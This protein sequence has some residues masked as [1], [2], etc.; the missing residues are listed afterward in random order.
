MVTFLSILMA[1]TRAVVYL[2]TPGFYIATARYFYPVVIPLMLLFSAGWMEISFWLS[3]L[4][5]RFR[6]AESADQEKSSLS[7][8]KPFSVGRF[9][10]FFGFFMVLSVLSFVSIIR[11]YY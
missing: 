7:Q 10:L 6:P 5:S 4:A 11:F 8:V 2:P 1:L 3:R 9:S